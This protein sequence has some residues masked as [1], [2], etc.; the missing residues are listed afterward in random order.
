MPGLDLAGASE[1]LKEFYLPPIRETLNRKTVL[2]QRLERNTEDFAG[3]RGYMPLHISRNEGV[4]ARAE[5]QTL[6]RA[7]SQGYDTAYFNMSNNYGRIEVSGPTIAAMAKDE[8][9]FTRAID[10][11]SREL[12]KDMLQDFNRQLF[13]DGSSELGQASTGATSATFTFLTTHYW[14]PTQHVRKNMYVDLINRTTGAFITNGENRKVLSVNNGVS[15]TLDMSVTVDTNT[16]MCRHGSYGIRTEVSPNGPK[17]MWGL[18]AIVSASNPRSIGGTTVPFGDIDR[19]SADA[20]FWKAEEVDALSGNLDLDMIQQGMDNVD[21]KTGGN[22]TLLLSD[23]VQ[24]R[25]HARLLTPDRRFPTAEGKPT[26]LDGG[27]SALYYDEVP[28]VRDKDCPP[29][30]IFGLDESTFQLFELSDLDWMDKDGA[31]LNRIN[32]EDAYEATLYCYKNLGNMN[33][34]ANFVIT[35][36]A[37]T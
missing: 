3:K 29:G 26:K 30:K 9:A 8:G 13:G 4:G 35:N 17:E 31:I 22:T 6:P 37:R 15:A 27:Y 1:L 10:S 5:R 23:Y 20:D 11:E 14:R 7:G 2:L 19:T 34:G 24:Y 28:H 25:K 32:N 36:L 12:T 33:P 21:I 16:I 18:G